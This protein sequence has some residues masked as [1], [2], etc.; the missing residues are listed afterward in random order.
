MANR[1]K[2]DNNIIIGQNIKNIRKELNLTQEEFAERLD[3]NTQYV[4]QFETGKVGISIDMAIRICKLANC[5]SA[6]LFKQVIDTTTI[7]KENEFVDK[8]E[9]LSSRDKSVISQMIL[10]LLNTK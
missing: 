10:Y 1:Y 8:Y 3:C 5:S 7:L 4:S 9:L 2:T 6:K